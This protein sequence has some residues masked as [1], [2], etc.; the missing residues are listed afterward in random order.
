MSATA[1]AAGGSSP[2]NVASYK[3]LDS[4][5]READ[6]W[7][8]NP[9]SRDTKVAIAKALDSFA[10]DYIE[11]TSPSSSEQ[12]L[13]D[14]KAIAALGLKAKLH[15]HVRDL[16]DAKKA[17][18]VDAG[19]RSVGLVV[20]AS[21]FSSDV[22]H[23]K[24]MEKIQE[25][26]VEVIAY[27]KSQNVETQFS[28][29]DTF[30]SDLVDLL[31]LYQAVKEAGADRVGINDIIGG[32]TPRLVDDNEELTKRKGVI[33]GDIE[34]RFHDETG[35]AVG[36]AVTAL[37]AGATHIDTTVLGIGERNGLVPLG[38]FSAR[39]L[40]AAPEYTKGKYNLKELKALETVVSEAVNINVPYNNPVTGFSAFTHK[41]GIHAKAILNNPSTYEVFDPAE[42]GI[43]RNVAINSRVTGW[44][45]VRSR[46]DQLG[47]VMTDDEVKA[48]TAKIKQTADTRPLTIEDTDNILHAFHAE[49]KKA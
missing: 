9:L 10:V 20:G 37:E 11:I 17:A 31:S 15:A 22:S 42:Y 18:S 39:M 4:T 3:I 6:Q 26:A 14:S 49:L 27:L 32:T 12:A 36:N 24:S 13:E 45:A 46:V 8:T 43:S 28:F 38:A 41:A 2:S 47:L 40:V 21:S 25:S 35:C 7:A 19:V 16:D 1:N 44:N 33:N 5:L 23:E 29:E 30:R 34:C 48:V